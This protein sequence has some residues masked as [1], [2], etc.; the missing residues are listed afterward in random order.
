MNNRPWAYSVDGKPERFY[1]TF[2][3]QANNGDAMAQAALKGLGITLLPDFIV[4]PHI[5]KKDL[6][7]VLQAFEPSPLGIYAVLPSNRYV[8]LR[9]RVLLEYLS[10]QIGKITPALNA[11]AG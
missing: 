8:P 5:L 3:M 7:V 10:E 9:V 11:S 6:K 2:V 1:P 4:A